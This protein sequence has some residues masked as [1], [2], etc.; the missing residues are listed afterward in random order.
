MQEQRQGPDD[1]AGANC[2]TRVW[3]IGV[4]GLC[5]WTFPS[6]LVAQDDAESCT[7]GRIARLRIRTQ[8][9]FEDG[10][11]A[12]GMVSLLTGALE[13][14]HVDTRERVIRRELLFDEGDCYDRLRLSESERLLREF[15]F[16]REASVRASR[17]RDGD[18]N[19]TVATQDDWSLRL[20]PRFD[21]GS[22]LEFSGASIGEIN[23]GG[24]GRAIRAFFF[25]RRGRNEYGLSF[26]EPQLVGSR[27]N[28]DLTAARTEPGF[29]VRGGVQYPFL[30]L[31][32]RRAAFQDVAIGERWFPFVVGDSPDRH[33][34]AVLPFRRRSVQV[35][36]AVRP[37]ITVEGATNRLGT[38]GASLSFEELRYESAFFR[39]SLPPGSTTLTEAEADRV[40][41]SDVEP[42]RTLRLN[43]LLGLQ[44]IAFVQRRGLSTL[45]ATEDV[46]V[47]IVADF[48]LGV[49]V[50]A[51][52]TDDSHVL[53]GMDTYGGLR[54]SPSFFTEFR[55]ILE[56]RRDYENQIW[57]DVFGGFDWSNFWFPGGGHTLELSARA[58]AAWNV[59]VPYQLTLG[60]PDA[61]RGYASHRYPGGARMVMTLED[62]AHLWS[63]G[64]L[65]DLGTAAFVDVGSTWSSGA[66]FGTNSGLRASAGT[67]LRI[68]TPSGSR[69]TYRLDLAVPI[70]DG[71]G[72][73]D[74][75]VRLR[76]QRPIR[77]DTGSVDGQLQRS[78]DL[79]LRSA[80]RY[81]K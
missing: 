25:D 18:V 57:R 61:L 41:R 35:G 48:V 80:S 5:L 15:S 24:T 16:L 39:D 43:F 66:P 53:A 70:E 75:V 40:A 81:L 19:V 65:F 63:V 28:L 12:S 72:W 76:L 38:L 60:G 1:P 49:A 64:N 29:F 3:L 20:D 58:A 13:W 33:A 11:S 71:I 44:G 22:G 59:T 14:L 74:V 69:L 42:R 47:G 31:V 50:P 7:D 55:G 8:G 45:R 17:R 30:G 54:L 36:G 77:L 73:D 51:L 68:A 6:D 79:S 9:V 56:G 34:E 67:A 23:V 78:R 4:L 21:F 27:W 32:G 2:R 37:G 10:D 26:F 46:P 52:G 62:R